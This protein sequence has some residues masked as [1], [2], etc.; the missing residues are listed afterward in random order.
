MHKQ[1]I[2]CCLIL[3]FING[4]VTMTRIGVFSRI[5]QAKK[6]EVPGLGRGAAY[7]MIVPENTP[8]PTKATVEEALKASNQSVVKVGSCYC[9]SLIGA[10]DGDIE[11]FVNKAFDEFRAKSQCVLGVFFG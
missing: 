6:G 10:T 11:Y 9:R 8:I 5:S 1:K 3:N 2:K 4:G 7:T